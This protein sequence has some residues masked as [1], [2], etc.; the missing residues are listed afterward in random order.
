[1]SEDNTLSFPQRLWLL[2]FTFAKIAALVVGGGLAMLPVIE[3][4]F[5]VKKKLLTKDEILDMVTLTQTVPGIIAANSAVYIGMKVAGFAGALCAL[6]GAIFP[7]FI[8]IVMIAWF[9]PGLSP[10]NPYYLGAFAGVRAG[11][12]GLIVVTA[13]KMAKK[14]IPGVVEAV[15]VCVFF[16]AAMFKLHPAAIIVSGMVFGVVYTAL[17]K[18]RVTAAAKGGK[19]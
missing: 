8:V 17:L 11:V 15:A 16:F 3:E 14:G 9:F 5:S 12:T 6:A 7:S 4:T 18:R 19:S 13:C 1:M 10:D 2:F